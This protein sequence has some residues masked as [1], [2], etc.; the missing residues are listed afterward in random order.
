MVLKASPC[1]ALAAAAARVRQCR[2]WLGAGRPPAL[3]SASVCSSVKSA[4]GYP[5]GWGGS[6]QFIYGWFVFFWVKICRDFAYIIISQTMHLQ[7]EGLWN[8]EGRIFSPSCLLLFF[9]FFFLPSAFIFTMPCQ[10]SGTWA[11]HH[12]AASLCKP[13]AYEARRGRKG[14]GS[15]FGRR[16]ALPANFPP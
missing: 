15:G 11:E 13:A 14:D 3:C 12:P 4:K 6:K 2:G 9:F 7:D 8:K 16:F 1:V 10:L 5:E